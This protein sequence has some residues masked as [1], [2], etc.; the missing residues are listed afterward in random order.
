MFAAHQV[1]PRL[2]AVGQT[3]VR[4]A[5]I[6]GLALMTVVHFGWRQS[7]TIAPW[8]FPEI[9]VLSSWGWEPDAISF[10]SMIALAGAFTFAI[11]ILIPKRGIYL[12]TLFFAALS[13]A[14]L[15]QTTRWQFAHGRSFGVYSEPAAAFRQLIQ[16]TALDGGIIIGPERGSLTY[17]LFNMRSRSKVVML[18]SGS[19]VDASIVGEN[20]AWMLLQGS[21]DVRIDG[22]HP[23]Y[24]TDKLV[25]LKKSEAPLPIATT[26]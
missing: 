25:L 19:V 22:L 18:P 21:Y 10:G 11:T 3:G 23:V 24:K 17:I 12:F 9:F 4:A 8:D 6:A 13:V 2:T 1:S 5:A 7:H 14:S 26:P 20:P 16:P 15:I